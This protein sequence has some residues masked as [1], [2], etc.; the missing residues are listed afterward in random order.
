MWVAPPAFDFGLLSI[1]YSN[2]GEVE[3]ATQ[4]YLQVEADHPC[5]RMSA[6]GCVS[7]DL[8]VHGPLTDLMGPPFE[9][10][11]TDLHFLLKVVRVDKD[12]SYGMYRSVHNDWLRVYVID[13]EGTEKYIKLHKTHEEAVQ[14]DH[15]CVV[16]RA[17]KIGGTCV[18]APR[19]MLAPAPMAY[20][21]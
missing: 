9:D 14:N 4:N 2:H 11:T 16:H 5:W 3:N 19:A 15:F 10:Q 12:L 18:V 7:W 8:R 21:W 20:R 1:H 17:R 13:E 6:N